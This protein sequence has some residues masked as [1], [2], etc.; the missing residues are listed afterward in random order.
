MAGLSSRGFRHSSDLDLPSEMEF[1]FARPSFYNKV[2]RLWGMEEGKEWT[3]PMP[4]AK[5]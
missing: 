4:P 3:F 1:D 2:F 5:G